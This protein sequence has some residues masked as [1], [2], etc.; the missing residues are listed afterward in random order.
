MPDYYVHVHIENHAVL[1]A[2]YN[3]YIIAVGL[4]CGCTGWKQQYQP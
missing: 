4:F 3:I 2:K 1:Y